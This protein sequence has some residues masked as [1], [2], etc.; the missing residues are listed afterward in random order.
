MSSVIASQPEPFSNRRAH[1]LVESRVKTAAALRL[2]ISLAGSAGMT[3]LRAYEKF[4]KEQTRK[5]IS[6]IPTE[7]TKRLSKL[8]SAVR[9]TRT[10]QM[11][12][13]MYVFRR[14][15]RTEA[16]PTCVLNGLTSLLAR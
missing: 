16:K 1:L 15:Q 13:P 8:Q 7:M 12:D 2:R 14:K 3:F 6:G 4:V 10:A 5:G 9:G 11:L